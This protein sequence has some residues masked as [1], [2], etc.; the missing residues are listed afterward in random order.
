MKINF[1]NSLMAILLAAITLSVVS[2]IPH[3][4]G[5]GNVVKEERKVSAF[6]ALEVSTGVEV[7]V[8]QDSIEKVVA[9]V[10][11]NLLKVLKTRVTG[12]VLKIYLEEGVLHAKSLKVYV[13]VKRLRSVETGSG[14]HVKSETKINAEK[15]KLSTSSGSGIKMEVNCEKLTAESSSGS[16]LT[17]S[18]NSQSLK[19]DTS[20]GSGIDASELVAEK[21]DLSASSGSHLKAQVT[22]E[23]KAHASS[24]AG[25]TVSGNPAV[26]DTDSSSGGSVHFR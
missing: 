13:T 4:R 15:L 7:L 17:V 21:G 2:C 6:E 11:S 12:D 18:G 24:G 1:R 14:S 5:N 25:I 16:H 23:I 19:A 3:L 20:S 10:D 8:N 9:E 22:K 26:R